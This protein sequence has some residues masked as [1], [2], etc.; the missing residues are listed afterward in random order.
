MPT[1]VAPFINAQLEKYSQD[2]LNVSKAIK[3]IQYK[4]TKFRLIQTIN[5]LL[6]NKESVVVGYYV[7]SYTGV[8]LNII[9]T[10]INDHSVY[11]SYTLRVYN[12]QTEY[13]IKQS[14]SVIITKVNCVGKFDEGSIPELDALFLNY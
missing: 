4:D 11:F 12:L 2:C 1:L 10:N 13:T 8:Y 14:N 5:G 9:I 3:K 6:L 7:S